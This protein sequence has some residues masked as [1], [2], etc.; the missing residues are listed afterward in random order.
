MISGSG[1]NQN[2]LK[3]FCQK[4]TDDCGILKGFLVENI[5]LCLFS[6]NSMISASGPNQNSQ[7]TPV[8]YA[9]D[10]GILLGFLVENIEQL[11]LLLKS[12]DFWVPE[13]AK[14]RPDW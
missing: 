8:K 7:K 3:N 6:L 9:D 14:F 5:W 2:S 10:S 12:N 4:R 11:P 13:M 1:P